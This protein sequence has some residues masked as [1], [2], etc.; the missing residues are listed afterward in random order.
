MR[1]S[2]NLDSNTTILKKMP[3]DLITKN[4]ERLRELSLVLHVLSS[5]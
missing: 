3:Q 4:Q 5:K 2:G 1:V